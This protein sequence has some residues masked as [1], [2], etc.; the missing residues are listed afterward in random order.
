[1]HTTFHSIRHYTLNFTQGTELVKF[2]NFIRQRKNITF[3]RVARGNYSVYIVTDSAEH[4]LFAM[5]FP[6]RHHCETSQVYSISYEQ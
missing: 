1:M 2:R 3:Y 6:Q 4:L 5:L